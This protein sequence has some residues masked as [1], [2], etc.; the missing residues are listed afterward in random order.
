MRL[1]TGGALEED[2]LLPVARGKP[3]SKRRVGSTIQVG[4][5]RT[6]LP[7]AEMRRGCDAAAGMPNPNR[8]TACQHAPALTHKRSVHVHAVF[9]NSV[10]SAYQETYFYWRHQAS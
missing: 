3:S 10:H 2:A 4:G 9:A 6:T 1:P 7:R 8:P 5:S